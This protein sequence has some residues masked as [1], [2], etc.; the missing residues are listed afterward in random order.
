MCVFPLN[1]CN[2]CMNVLKIFKKET[3]RQQYNVLLCPVADTSLLRL[4]T[5][6][7]LDLLLPE[8]YLLPHGHNCAQIR[9]SLKLY[10]LIVI[11]T[12]DRGADDKNKNY[13]S[14]LSNLHVSSSSVPYCLHVASYISV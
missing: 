13:L 7:N 12:G 4:V 8:L 2:Y 5:H 6:G 11:Y 1:F 9:D 14:D 10:A 3:G